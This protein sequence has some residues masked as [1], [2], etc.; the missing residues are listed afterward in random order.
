MNSAVTDESLIAS[1]ERLMSALRKNDGPAIVAQYT[2][3]VVFMPPNDQSIY[4]K[5]EVTE[6]FKEYI[7]NFSIKGLVETD[8]HVTMLGD[9]ALVRWTYQVAIHPKGGGDRILD[10]GRMMHIWS[11][12][13]DGEWRIAQQI[14]NSTRPIGSGTSRFMSLLKQRMNAVTPET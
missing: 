8:R 2:D 11:R 4:G 7:S 12:C 6:W 1:H 9:W 14:W 3:D 13:A 5:E 10:E